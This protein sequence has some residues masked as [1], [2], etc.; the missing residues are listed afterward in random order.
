MIDDKERYCVSTMSSINDHHV[1]LYF[2]RYYKDIVTAISYVSNKLCNNDLVII[3]FSID[4][5]IN[6][7]GYLQKRHI[8]K[9]IDKEHWSMYRSIL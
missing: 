7:P 4:D 9:V 6:N 8:S 3:C 1:Y 2:D 5:Y